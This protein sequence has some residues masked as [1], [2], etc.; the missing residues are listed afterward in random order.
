MVHALPGL[1]PQSRPPVLRW[2]ARRVEGWTGEPL[3]AALREGP[4]AERRA[5]LE[6]LAALGRLAGGADRAPAGGDHPVE[7]PWSWS[8]TRSRSAS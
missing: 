3:A 6:G 5:V 8:S 4:D 7:S 1:P 2:L